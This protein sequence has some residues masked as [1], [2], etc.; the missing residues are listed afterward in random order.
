M[1]KERNIG[2]DALRVLAIFTVVLIHSASTDI[3]YRDGVLRYMPP[4]NACFAFLA[5][6]FLFKVPGEV[7]IR[8][9]GQLV[10]KRVRRLVVP[11][12]AWESIYVLFNMVFDLVAGQ[13]QLP[14]P[15]RWWGIVFLGAGSVQ[16]WFV[17]T[18]IYVQLTLAGV[19]ALVALSKRRISVRLDIC[20]IALF[21]LI[22]IIVLSWR[23]SGIDGDYL[24]RF[25]FLL[26]YG[27]LG[28]G[29]RFAIALINEVPNRRIVPIIGVCGIVASYVWIIPEI[30]TVLAWCLAFGGLPIAVFLRNMVIKGS[31]CVMGIYLCHVL[32]T[33]VIAMGVPVVSRVIPN[34]YVLTIVN[35]IIGFGIS[36]TFV[37][38]AKR[39]KWGRFVCV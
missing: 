15:S 28:V 34:G 11:Y 14:E 17:A 10:V 6:W 20:V 7:S 8:E 32:F 36:L 9:V 38:M 25:A 35:A 16:L 3:S 39:V 13:F 4:A 30:V 12:L 33:R 21:N 1:V 26:G 22:A 27:A 31:G 24:R 2:L 23:A 37:L 18:L 29:L 5:G 19:M